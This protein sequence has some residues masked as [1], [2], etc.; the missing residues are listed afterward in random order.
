MYGVSSPPTRF[1]P[2]A[3]SNPMASGC[4]FPQFFTSTTRSAS[5]GRVNGVQTAPVRAR[6]LSPVGHPST[7]QVARPVT[8]SQV[9]AYHTGENVQ[10]YQSLQ[11]PGSP[12]SPVN[13]PYVQPLLPQQH[14]MPASLVQ[15]PRIE[16][17]VSAPTVPSTAP[18]T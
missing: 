8:I 18:T 9:P 3:S 7:P 16:R 17:F 5:A 2:V 11:W 4:D 12:L 6:S 15:A 1:S 14:T 10:S 13:H